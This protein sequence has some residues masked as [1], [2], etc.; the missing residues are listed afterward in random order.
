MVLHGGIKCCRFMAMEDLR[1]HCQR[2][3][4]LGDFP[5]VC[6]LT[7]NASKRSENFHYWEL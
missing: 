2:L 4:I 6:P 1:S 3:R 7:K 5:T